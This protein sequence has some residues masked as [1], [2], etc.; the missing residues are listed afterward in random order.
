[1]SEGANPAAS[2]FDAKTQQ[3]TQ[4]R[5]ADVSRQREEQRYQQEQTDRQDDAFHKVVQFAG[6]G[7]I[8]EAKY[9]AQKRGLQVP[10][11][12]FT[13][14]DFAK[15][16]AISRDLYAHDPAQAQKF[17]T[18][19][20]ATQGD[21]PTKYMAARTAAGD[22][23]SDDDRDYRNFVRKEQFK[24][25]HEK[26][27]YDNLKYEDGTWYDLSAKG[28][29]APAGG[30]S[31]GGVSQKEQQET[32]DKAYVAAIEMGGTVE[33]GIAAGNAAVEAKNQAFPA[34]LQRQTPEM[35]V[36]QNTPAAGGASG[37]T[38]LPAQPAAPAQ[39]DPGA[40][41]RAT[42]DVQQALMG[43]M[44]PDQIKDGLVQRGI[45]PA[46]AQA[47]I[48]SVASGGQGGQNQAAPESPPMMDGSQLAKPGWQMI[49][50]NLQWSP[51]QG[52]SRR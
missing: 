31:V 42:Y 20:Q 39:P 27:S 44:T 7:Y 19:W 23:I 21:L 37:L 35:P 34:A 38:S 2:A 10:E 43:G 48:E 24:M 1:M 40:I 49:R 26:P 33:K 25:A 17:A 3:L 4:Q 30:G 8:E 15:G 22:P 46:E 9:F 47:F 5:D 29:P 14:A 36:M 11:Q 41:Q 13:N 52:L 6:D 18:A 28:G 12:V 45:P 16:L 32:W 51:S 50:D